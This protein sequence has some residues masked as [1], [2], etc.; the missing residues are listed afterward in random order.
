VPTVHEQRLTLRVILAFFIIYF[1]WGSTYLAIRIAV[2]T[3]PPL[4]AAGIRF[5]VAGAVLLLWSKFRGVPNPT[6][7][8]WRNLA[9][10]AALMFL[11]GYSALFWAETEIPSGVASVL[12]A[13]TP[14]WMALVEIAIFKR[15]RLH[16]KLAM[17]ICL[18]VAGVAL[19]AL[20]RGAAQIPLLPCLAILGAQLAW[21]LGTVLSQTVRAPA[22][23]VLTAGAQM[24]LGGLMLFFCSWLAGE[25][26]PWPHISSQAAGALLYLIIAGSVVAFTAYTWLLAHMPATIVSSYAYVNPVVALA[27][28]YWLGNEALNRNILIGAALVLVSVLLIL[29]TRTVTH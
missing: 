1:V 8:E 15:E 28:G 2:A 27:I 21:S 24:T 12:I 26:T 7:V 25:T 14:V 5:S 6:P 20:H 3:V 10:Q 23:K 17:A 29:R 16:P 22:S 4:F 11:C 18:G 9:V 13:T 19:L